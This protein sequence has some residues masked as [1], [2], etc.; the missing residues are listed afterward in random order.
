[1]LTAEKE[2]KMGLFDK[3]LG[4]EQ[5]LPTLD[6]GSAAARHVERFKAHLEP[7]AARVKDRLELVPTDQAIYIYVGKPPSAFGVAWIGKDG[8]E[9][10]FKTLM[11]ERGLTPQMVQIFSDKLRE[12]YIRE[13]DAPRFSFTLAGRSVKVAPDDNLSRDVARIIAE[14]DGKE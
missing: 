8:K 2:A 5:D 12:A 14:L 10:N 6:T 1:M 11:Q 13:K 3:I 7:F 4:K 9:N